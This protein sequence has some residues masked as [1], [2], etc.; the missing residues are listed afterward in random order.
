MNRRTLLV[1]LGC[2]VLFNVFFILGAMQWRPK[3][4]AR[5]SRMTTINQVIAEMD[6]DDEQRGLF[7]QMRTEYEAE[8]ELLSQRIKTLQNSIAT[9]LNTDEPDLEQVDALVRQQA[10]LRHERRRAGSERFEVFLAILNP[11]QRHALGR[12]MKSHRPPGPHGP[13]R[14][15]KKFDLNK[16]GELEA[17][18]QKAADEFMEERR[19]R[20]G[21]DLGALHDRYDLDGDGF[22]SP[23][24]ERALHDAQRPRPRRRGGPHGS[25]PPKGDDLAPPSHP[26]EP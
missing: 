4:D 9:A 1:L 6:L 17:D 2:S 3:E 7:E 8:S 22:L 21:K 11:E 12:R 16:N 13:D 10:A 18:E 24:E 23:A 25:P 26:E 14:A 19:R 15:L 5:T 20:R